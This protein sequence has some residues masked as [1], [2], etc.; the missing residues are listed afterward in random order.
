MDR[1]QPEIR[2]PQC[3]YRPRLAD[4]WHCTPEC[5]TIWHTF[6]TA[7]VCPG[8]ARQWK[9]TQCP[10]CAVTSPHRA[11][12]HLPED[13]PARSDEPLTAHGSA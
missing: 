7:G 6:W 1:R 12:Y 10:S 9:T 5:A 2:C 4:R 11:W 8:C 3:S 13:T